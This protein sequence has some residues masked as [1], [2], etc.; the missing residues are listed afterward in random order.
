MNIIKEP[1]ALVQ[2]PFGTGVA[3]VHILLPSRVLPL[4]ATMQKIPNDLIQAGA[5]LGGSPSHTFWRIFLPLSLPGILAGAT[6]VFGLCLG[7]FITPELLGCVRTL[8]G[9][10]LGSRTVEVYNHW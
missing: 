1:V 4:Y 8:M 2:N 9:S 10:M 3:P 5:S 6:L 7:F